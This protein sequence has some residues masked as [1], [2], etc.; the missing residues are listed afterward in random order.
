MKLHEW[1]ERPYPLI[2]RIRDKVLLVLGFGL[3][4]YLFLILYQ[5]FGAEQI[6]NGREIFLLGFGASVTLGLSIMYLL[7]P[8]FLP[9]IFDQNA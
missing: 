9:K 1:L 5:P 2:Q 7:V 8:I 3:F 6:Q 4:T